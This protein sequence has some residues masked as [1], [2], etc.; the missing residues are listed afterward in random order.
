MREVLLGIITGVA[1]FAITNV[2]DIFVLTI[3]FSQ[4]RRGFRAL[5]VVAG[6]FGGFTLLLTVCLVAFFGLQRVPVAWIGLLGFVPIVLAV[7]RW[8]YRKELPRRELS[9]LANTGSIAAITFAN[10]SDNIAVY[11]PLFANSDFA[12][13]LVLIS[14]FYVLVTVWCLAGFAIN[15]HPTIGP[16]LA[17]RERVIMP[18]L[19]FALGIYIIVSSST[20]R[21]FI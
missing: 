9:S 2:D 19:L 10:G 1:T 17:R 21:L 15:R 8:I 12:R 11:I 16:L 20:Y 13:M 3:L 5:H 18:L 4:R 7:R 6:H 14:T